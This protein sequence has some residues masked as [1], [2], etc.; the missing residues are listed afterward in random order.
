M[1]WSVLSRCSH[2]CTVHSWSTSLANHVQ[3]LILSGPTCYIRW[4][5]GSLFHFYFHTVYIW[6]SSVISLSLPIYCLFISRC[7][8]E[9]L[10]K[11]ILFLL[12]SFLCVAMFMSIYQLFSRS[13]YWNVLKVLFFIFPFWCSRFRADLVFHYSWT[14]RLP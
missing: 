10:L 1:H 9:L 8:E 7:F 12:L 2:A 6:F 3:S 14:H 4:L 5:C 11:E 13:F